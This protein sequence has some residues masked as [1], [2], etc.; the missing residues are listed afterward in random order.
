MKK[1]GRR[2]NKVTKKTA[3]AYSGNNQPLHACRIGQQH[4][5]TESRW[6][7]DRV[8]VKRAMD[9]LLETIERSLETVQSCVET[10]KRT[11]RVSGEE[12]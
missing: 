2:Q 5:F 12:A 10:S 9:R 1:K 8:E 6:N 7:V 4:P 11:L 3:Q